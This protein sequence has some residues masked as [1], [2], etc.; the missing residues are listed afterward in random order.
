MKIFLGGVNGVGKTTF[1][2]RVQE[3]MPDV[4]VVDG[5]KAF[6][7]WLGIPGDYDKLRA[8]DN[9]ERNRQRNLFIP[10][11]LAK[12][13]GKDVIFAAHYLNLVNGEVRDVSPG[14]WPK[15]FDILAL[16]TAPAQHIYERIKKESRDRALFFPGTLSEEEQKALKDYIDLTK[17]KALEVSGQFGIRYVEIDNSNGRLDQAVE[18]FVTLFK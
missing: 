13:E 8:M 5:T 15:S 7:E 10:A 14:E 1:I 17:T 2:T 12:H 11:T 4:V 3:A 9:G 18:E 6:M 16:L